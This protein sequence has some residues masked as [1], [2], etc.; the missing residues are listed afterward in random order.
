MARALLRSTSA[1]G[2]LVVSFFA[3]APVEPKGSGKA[4]VAGAG[5][6]AGTTAS[7]GSAGAFPGG[8]AGLGAGAGAGG[9]S[10]TVGS[11]GAGG[12]SDAGA[13]GSDGGS[14]G[15]AS[16]E[17]PSCGGE[18]T[19]CGSDGLADCCA[20]QMVKGMS[21]LQGRGPEDDA[22]GF[23]AEKPEHTTTVSA[24]S[25][26]RYEATVGRF[27][28]FLDAGAPLPVP[29]TS[30]HPGH[31]ETAWQAGWNDELPTDREGWNKVLAC[32]PHTTWTD[33]PGD[34]E[35]VSMNC[36]GW[37]AAYA[38]CAWEG[39]RL[40]TEAEWE[41]AAA[42]GDQNRRYPWGN[43]GPFDEQASF[44][45]V[46]G[47]NGDGLPFCSVA[48]IRRPGSYPLGVGRYNHFDLAGNVAEWMLDAYDEGYYAGE[49]N[50]CQDCVSSKGENRSL[51]GGS[52]QAEEFY[53]R[54]AAR[55]SWPPSSPVVRAGVR[56]AESVPSL[57]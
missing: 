32:H 27:R 18:K 44:H 55:F 25:L 49:G 11:S 56:C 33:D 30:G 47:C 19:G 4:T 31:P 17:R 14:G 16:N 26:D 36:L 7:A 40:P 41:L 53:L 13:A 9:G 29:G 39:A 46:E 15:A 37:Y 28:R 8:Q 6:A 23:E 21:Y 1:M 38:F 35:N 54:S 10:G 22:S 24:F 50:A 5:G 57:P 2:A 45:P 48:D 42:G 12:S 52:F 20:R 34:R 3:C 51:R 43:N